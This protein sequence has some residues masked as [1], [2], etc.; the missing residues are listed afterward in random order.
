MHIHMGMNDEFERNKF[1]RVFFPGSP[2]LASHQWHP[3]GG[4][5]QHKSG[6]SI[7]NKRIAVVCLVLGER[8]WFLPVGRQRSERPRYRFLV[9]HQRDGDSPFWKKECKRE[10]SV[11]ALSHLGGVYCHCISIGPAWTISKKNKTEQVGR[12]KE[13][14]QINA[15]RSGIL[16]SS[17]SNKVRDTQ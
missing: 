12:N 1:E 7:S 3:G 16:N 11:H 8:R 6:S 2:R 5:R 10:S 9:P 4:K 15:G 17:G 14:N 13:N